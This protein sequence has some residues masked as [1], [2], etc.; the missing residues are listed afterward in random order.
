[1][2]LLLLQ[3]PAR[4]FVCPSAAG[5]MRQASVWLYRGRQKAVKYLSAREI[6]VV[7]NESRTSNRTSDDG[8]DVHYDNSV[9][10]E[11]VLLLLS[12]L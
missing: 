1:M 10:L 9:V 8:S 4:V 6:S 7:L 11:S 5:F 2:L 3:T 12:F